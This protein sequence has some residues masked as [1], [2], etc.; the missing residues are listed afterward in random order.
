MLNRTVSNSDLG[1][2]WDA[3]VIGAGPSGSMAAHQLAVRKQKVLLID[4]SSFPRNKVCGCC[5]SSSGGKALVQAGLGSLLKSDIFSEL[6]QLRLFN[7][8]G[9]AL[10]SIPEGF[11]VSREDLDISL[12]EA[13]VSK[14]VQ[15][16]PEATATV[17]SLDSLE[18]AALIDV[19]LSGESR[20]LAAKVV[21]VADGLSGKS[22][23]SFPEFAPIVKPNARF[24]AG[25]TIEDSTRFYQDGRIYMALGDFGYVGVVRLAS[26][27]LDVAAA[28]DRDFS[29]ANAGPLGAAA[30]IL[31]NCN[32]PIP[33]GFAQGHW[34]GTEPL[35]RARR[36]IAGR[37]L[38]VIGDSCGYPE[39]FTG[40]G[41]AWALWSGILVADLAQRAA[42]R[43]DPAL[44]RAW[45]TLHAKNI[46]SRQNFS[47]L[48]SLALRYPW[49]RAAAVSLLS[50]RPGMAKPLVEFIGSSP[51]LSMLNGVYS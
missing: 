5:L 15:F 47:R 44:V 39:P 48:L 4:K 14:G 43:P 23:S 35:T 9:S 50:A 3:I 49:F 8:S 12:I 21:L 37:R 41:M 32:L 45:T 46:T 29:R 31:Q 34:S 1:K 38:F 24:G 7:G 10:I 11:S 27:K 42:T 28:F 26:G 25:T 13:A 6:D 30:S 18:P 22:L 33:T 20:R 19:S 2:T 51:N 17:I 36:R 16:L 40:E